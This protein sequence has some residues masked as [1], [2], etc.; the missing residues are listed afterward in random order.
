[1]TKK[2][3]ALI[4]TANT[5][6]RARHV[7]SRNSTPEEKIGMALHL[8]LA[9]VNQAVKRYGIDHC[10]FCLEGRSFRKDMYAPYKRNR[11]VD[12]MSITEEEAEESK[13][14]WDTYEK[15]T[16]YIREKTNVTVLRHERAEADDMIARFIHLHPMDTHYI[17]STDGDYAQLISKNVMQYNGVTGELITLAGY[18]KENGKPVID[19]KT[20][21][22]KL[23]EDP[24]YGLFRKIVRGDAGDNVFSA[25][26]GCREKG[27]KNKVGIREAFDDRNKQGFNY[28]N[29]ML[30]RYTDHEGNEV[31]VK[32][33][34]ERNRQLIDLTAQPQEIKDA[35]D[36]RIRESVRV[37][38]VPQVGIH[39]LKFTGK[40]ELTKISEQA[41]T[42]SR[43]LNAPYQG[44]VHERS[45]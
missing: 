39:F 11:V 26:P 36:Q 6:F 8:T 29:F 41:E 15:F 27:T 2:S 14:F 37:T 7:A 3:Y 31:R 21:E 18:L 40:Y 1:M 45:N 20:K 35:V 34:F 13:L 38:T 44:N 9:S 16:T 10:V 42:Y 5:F 24:E 30:Q 33:A 28:N 23:L 32:D 12:A 25:F 17:I 22:P 19:K 43:W 4:D